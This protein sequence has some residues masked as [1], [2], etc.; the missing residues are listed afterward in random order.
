MRRHGDVFQVVGETIECCD[1]GRVVATITP[2]LP[3]SYRI[4]LQETLGGRRK[5]EQGFEEG[6]REE[7]NRTHRP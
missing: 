4:R 5:W 6:E 1:D 7:R 3:L 2:G